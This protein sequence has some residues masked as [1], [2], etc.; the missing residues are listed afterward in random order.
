MPGQ[1]IE[2]ESPVTSHL[3]GVHGWLIL[4]AISLVSG[5]I[6]LAISLIWI[7]SSYF[8]AAPEEYSNLYN[9]VILI[10]L[11]LL[12]LVLYVSI[13]FFG[14][15]RDAPFMMIFLMVVY[16][17]LFGYLFEAEISYDYVVMAASKSFK[18]LIGG[19]I[20]DAIWIPYF[21]VSKRVNATFVR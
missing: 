13:R 12:I 21:I 19:I 3:V 6:F 2:S 15:K 16:I 20:Y 14:K 1:R 5:T 8:N 11:V 4:P 17:L 18:P 10:E 9:S 7:L